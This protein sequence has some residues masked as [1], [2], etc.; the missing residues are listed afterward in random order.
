[1]V[2]V[3][4][5]NARAAADAASRLLQDPFLSETLDEMTQLATDTAIR[6]ANSIVREEARQEVLAIIK[7]RGSLQT[8][9]ESWQTAAAVLQQ[10]R[11][12]E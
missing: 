5:A 6:G 1:M 7:L 11:A 10:R 4:D 3:T 12:H 8:V 2:H 9:F